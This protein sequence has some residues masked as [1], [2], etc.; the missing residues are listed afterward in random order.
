MN[1]VGRWLTEEAK[2]PHEIQWENRIYSIWRNFVNHRHA[3]NTHCIEWD[4]L[5]SMYLQFI[6]HYAVVVRCRDF[7]Q[8][9]YWRKSCVRR[10][11]R[12]AKNMTFP[13]RQTHFN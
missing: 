5:I 6:Q 11:Y 4:E 9:S 13:Y 8:Q 2:W 3:I 1:C 7:V 12:N 10:V